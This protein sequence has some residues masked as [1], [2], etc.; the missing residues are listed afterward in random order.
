MVSAYFSRNRQKMF[1][2][3][4]DFHD[5][6]DHLRFEEDT[7]KLTYM[8]W[9][10]FHPTA[11]NLLYYGTPISAFIIFG[12]GTMIALHLNSFFSAG[13]MGLFTLL[14]GWDAWR[15]SKHFAIT[16]TRNFYDI[17]VRD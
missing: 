7:R 15:K 9:F 13:I 8:E 11:Y 2:W 14:M 4:T 5:P 16:K 10:W 3:I 17:F 1:P 12:L 6:Q